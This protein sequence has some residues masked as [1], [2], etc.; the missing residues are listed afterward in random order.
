MYLPTSTISSFTDVASYNKAAG[1]GIWWSL[2]VTSAASDAHPFHIL[3]G[4]SLCKTHHFVNVFLN[5][6]T[7]SFIY[8]PILYMH[9]SKKCKEFTKDTASHKIFL[10]YWLK[11]S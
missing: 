11:V 5:V 6:L 4:P 1:S 10:P 7:S 2:S 3:T 8:M 9:N